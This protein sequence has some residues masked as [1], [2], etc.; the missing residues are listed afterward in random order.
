[1]KVKEVYEKICKSELHNG[2]TCIKNKWIFKI[3]PNGIFRAR[4]GYIQ[5]PGVDF[6]ESFAPVINDFERKNC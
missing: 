5:V 3:K 2:R 1:M 6:H 4:R